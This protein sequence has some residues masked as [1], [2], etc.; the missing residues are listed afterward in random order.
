MTFASSTSASASTTTLLV[1]LASL[2]AHASGL[3]DHGEDLYAREKFE[4]AL[5]GY[6]RTRGELL[7]NFDLDRG[8]TPSGRGLFATPL[9]DPNAQ[10]LMNAD[11]RLRTDLAV[12][13]PF[14][15]V[16]VKLRMDLIDDVVLGS[17]PSLSPG[18]G[19]APTPAT[20]PGQLP[21]TLFRLKR[22]YGEAL[23]PF[24]FLAAGRMGSHWGL[25]LLSNGGDC[26]DCDRGDAA[27]RIAFVTPIFGH[28]VAAA[29]DFS[30]VGP[31]SLRPDA[32]RSVVI[33]PSA[34]VHSMSFAIMNPKT[35]LT[36]ERRRRAKKAT[37]EY[38]VLA[39]HRWQAF[40]VPQSYL[41]VPNTALTASQVVPRG[42]S[43]TVFDVW[44]RVTAPLLRIELEGALSFAN[45]QQ[46][47]LIPGVL[48]RDS[49]SSL[50]W[51][52][53]LEVE[54]GEPQ[55]RF[56]GGLNAGIASGDP[57]P[58]FGAFPQAGV[59][60]VAGELDAPQVDVPRDV[61]ADNFR[62]HPD[63]RIDR[64]L[65]AEIIGTVTD[66]LYVR[67]WLQAKV[68]D[69]GVS[70]LKARVAATYTRALYASSTPGGNENLGLELHGSLRWEA[71]DGFDALLEY[72]VLF[73][74]AGL[75][76]P[77]QGLEARPAQLLRLR[78]AWVF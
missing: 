70:A 18:T 2:G 72:A 23:T 32:I 49:V 5:G 15:A 26:L 57:A 68:I 24:G 50:Q 40:D 7:D 31:L 29:Y 41:N 43:A 20:T 53:A 74:F 75:S 35:P 63:Y 76:N 52:G 12:Y 61:R 62:F 34:N 9:G 38:G 77:S 54:V 66:C 14:A 37:V 51:G 13:A 11:M 25:G 42:F 67:P 36:V 60:P 55:T 47:S 30:A 4:V 65:Y 19:N 45:V 46:P 39:S 71:R 17:T 69:A 78:L 64:I 3:M 28:L 58:G 10:L 16:A 33:E 6:L 21:H 56:S 73:P 44:A 27:D 22:A 59:K 1:L 48:L 8:T